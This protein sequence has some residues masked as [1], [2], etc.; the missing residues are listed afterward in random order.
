MK[1]TGET[2][3]DSS[4]RLCGGVVELKSNI[5]SAEWVFGGRKYGRG[6]AQ[7]LKPCEAGSRW[8]WLSKEDS[9][10]DA[11]WDARWIEDVG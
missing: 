2:L 9:T 4:E 1:V 7:T 11:R 10:P 5:Q 8:L 3:L 6:S